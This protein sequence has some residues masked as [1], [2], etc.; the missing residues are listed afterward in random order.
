MTTDDATF[1]ELKDALTAADA[2][3]DD[4]LQAAKDSYTWRTIDAELAELVFDSSLDE[5]SRSTKNHTA[6]SA[7]TRAPTI[8]RWLRF[9]RWR[10][11]PVVTAVRCS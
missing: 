4:V 6:T 10:S 7:T 1:D 3:P 5:S 9:M 2:V 8:R 11:L